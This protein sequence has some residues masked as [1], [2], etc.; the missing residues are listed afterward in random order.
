M[1]HFILE[2]AEL[3][4]KIRNGAATKDEVDRFEVETKLSCMNYTVLMHAIKQ[5]AKERNQVLS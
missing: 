4:K 2:I 1:D 5:A 3:Y